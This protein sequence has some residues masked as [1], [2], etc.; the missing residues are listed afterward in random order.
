MMQ[1]RPLR[2]DDDRSTFTCGDDDLNCFF[3]KYAGQNQ[4]RLHIGTTYVAVEGNRILGF[5]TIAAT[6]LSVERL[7]V[8]Q[9]KRLPHY[10]LPALRV[11]RLAVAIDARGKA[12]GKALL[13]AALRIARQ[14]AERVGCIGV[15]VDA[16][17][18][19]ISFYERYGFEPL[20]VISGCLHDRPVPLPMFLPL[21]SIPPGGK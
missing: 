6:S 20:E 9:K 1:I 16:K 21:G 7:P 18:D 11:A 14:M 4:F 12:I 5:V 17:R 3:R 10:P 8:R 15:I 2:T 13:G 19:A